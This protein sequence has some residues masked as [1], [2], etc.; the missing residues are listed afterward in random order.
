MKNKNCEK[1][2]QVKSGFNK[3]YTKTLTGND[4]QANTDYFN[5]ENERLEALNRML[6]RFLAESLE[7]CLINEFEAGDIRF[8]INDYLTAHN[9]NEIPDFYNPIEDETNDDF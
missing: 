1:I 8:L 3:A 6:D 7:N 5:T 2:K 9:K 4:E